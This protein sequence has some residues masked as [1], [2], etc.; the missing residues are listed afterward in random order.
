M[1]ACNSKRLVVAILAIKLAEFTKKTR[2]LK[3]K[4]SK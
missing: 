3:T 1:G 4:N 2:L